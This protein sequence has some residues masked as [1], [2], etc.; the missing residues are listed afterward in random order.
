[1]EPVIHIGY[2]KTATTFF[3]NQIFPN[4]I[5]SSLISKKEI[6]Q[7]I[8]KPNPINFNPQKVKDYLSIKQSKKI[9]LSYERLLGSSQDG[10]LNLLLSI[11]NA[12]KLKKLFPKAQIVIFIRNQ[13]GI[14]A[15]TYCQYLYGGGTYNIDN[16]LFGK[17]YPGP[18]SI[19]RFNFDFFRY[20][21]LIDYYSKLFGIEN[22]HIFL[23]EDLKSNNQKFLDGFLKELNLTIDHTKITFTKENIKY[24]NRI[25]P[26]VRFLNKFTRRASLDKNYFFHIPGWYEYSR[27]FLSVINKMLRNSS[28]NKNEVLKILSKKNF[29]FINEYYKDSNL[30][31][32]QKFGLK[33]VK[34]YKYPL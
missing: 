14:I 15:S 17:F 29:E 23:Y 13:I 9:I 1:M 5:D 32:I 20:E 3:Q 30:K 6:Y 8:I 2:P 12:E 21:L 34:T 22:I 28:K 18:N 33:G 16:F 19:K 11:T 4:I 25:I 31:L 10:G 24:N 7:L 27:K 26:F